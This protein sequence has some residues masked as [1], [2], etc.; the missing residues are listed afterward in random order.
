MSDHL[1]E[2]FTNVLIKVCL[3]F[4]YSMTGNFMFNWKFKE[5]VINS[6]KIEI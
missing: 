2:D 4:I 5:A 3:L 6:N 1:G